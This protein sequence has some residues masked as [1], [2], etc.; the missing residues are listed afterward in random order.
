MSKKILG[1]VSLMIVTI[2]LIGC[3]IIGNIKGDDKD[4][5]VDE[6]METVEASKNMEEKIVDNDDLAITVTQKYESGSRIY[7]EIGYIVQ[8][9]NR[10]SDTDLEITISDMSVNGKKNKPLW[11]TTVASGSQLKDEIV[12]WVGDKSDKYNPNVKTLKDLKNVKGTIVVSDC[13][14]S[15]NIGKYKINIK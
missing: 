15:S 4:I 10:K 3:S 8:I 6:E 13:K 12:W 11:T 9:I 1:L 5:S 7:K 14:T 2:G